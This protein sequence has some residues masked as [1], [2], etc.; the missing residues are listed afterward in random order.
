MIIKMSVEQIS[1]Q[2]LANVNR[3]SGMAR[4]YDANRPH[5]PTALLHVIG[6]FIHASRPR[7]VVDLG[8]GTGLSTRFWA[9]HAE[10]VIGIEPNDDMLSWARER[11]D[12]YT[13]VSYRKG[14]ADD[15]GLPDSCA[16]IVMCAQSLHWMEPKSAMREVCR[17]LRRDGVFAFVHDCD[18]P[19]MN[20]QVVAALQEF[21]SR[22]ANLIDIAEK[23][24]PQQDTV[25]SWTK[26]QHLAYMQESKIFRVIK[27]CLLHSIE[28]GNAER[29]IGLQLSL[30]N[31]IRLLRR[32][33]TEEEIGLEKLR[34]VAKQILGDEYS[35][36]YFSFDTLL[37]VK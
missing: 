6:E 29:L 32:G 11:S 35:P 18:L 36:W 9:E 17:I 4:C 2:L 8:S 1:Q 7:L 12:G 21:R 19:T 27:S 14:L 30:G 16:D 25:V 5:P 28:M 15:T 13:N 22:I 26:A 20:W 37:T 23:E 34:V 24:D 10:E 31:T 3:F 33:F